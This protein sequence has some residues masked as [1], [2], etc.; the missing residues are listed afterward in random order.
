ML[1]LLPWPGSAADAICAARCPLKPTPSFCS[2]ERQLRDTAC[3]DR[4]GE[5]R[6]GD[7]R[8][9]ISLQAENTIA[10]DLCTQVN[11]G[12][13]CCVGLTPPA[14]GGEMKYKQTRDQ[15]AFACSRRSC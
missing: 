15:L 2:G 7:R 12:Y 4:T 8:A 5:H 1:Q 9:I 14:S 10:A 6:G 11:E 3:P 13:Y